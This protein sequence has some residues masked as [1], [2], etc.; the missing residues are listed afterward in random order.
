MYVKA[1]KKLEVQMCVCLCVCVYYLGKT[2]E[3]DVQ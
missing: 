3:R 2:L 1:L